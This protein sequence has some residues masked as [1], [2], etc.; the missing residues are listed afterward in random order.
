MIKLLQWGNDD[1]SEVWRITWAWNHKWV[2]EY[3][4]YNAQKNR[5]EWVSF[6][7]YNTMAEAQYAAKQLV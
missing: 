3:G 4:E 6:G 1:C 7:M 5:I 2:L